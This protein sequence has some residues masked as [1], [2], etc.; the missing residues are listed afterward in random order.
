MAE[1]SDGRRSRREI[2]LRREA[3][4][5]DRLHSQG[6]KV[7]AGYELAHEQ[8][9]VAV[10][11]EVDEDSAVQEKGREDLVAIA[12]VF[13]IRIGAQS[14]AGIAGVERMHRDETRRIF[15]RERSQE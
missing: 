10:S 15:D 7:I 6:R 3:A 2:L 1:H 9:G 5:H 11:V 8:L 4:A 14:E 12:V 13:V